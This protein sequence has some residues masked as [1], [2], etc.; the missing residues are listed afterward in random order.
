[1]WF[2]ADRL[3]TTLPSCRSLPGKRGT[4]LKV[5]YEHDGSDTVRQRPLGRRHG[6]MTDCCTWLSS[7]PTRLLLRFLPASHF[8]TR[9]MQ[10]SRSRK[11]SA[12]MIVRGPMVWRK[13]LGSQAIVPHGTWQLSIQWL[14]LK[15]RRV[16]YRQRKRS[17]SRIREKASQAQQSVIQPC[18]LPS[19]CGDTWCSGWWC[20]RI[21]GRDRQE[22]NVVYSR[23]AGAR[24]CTS[25]FQWRFSGLTP[26][27]WPT[28][29]RF[30]RP[31]WCSSSTNSFSL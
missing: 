14:H 26:C 17:N 20:A 12:G 19:G 22:G 29:W 21:P 4:S 11:V 16:R 9:K 28:R 31:W 15:C 25:V 6:W 10:P 8:T 7:S 1:M 18:L 5:V 2:P 27:A 30:L 3:C 24:S 13:Y 23:S